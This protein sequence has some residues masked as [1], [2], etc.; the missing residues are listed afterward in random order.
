MQHK[1]LHHILNWTLQYTC[2]LYFLTWN[3]NIWDK[4]RFMNRSCL[5]VLLLPP[6]FWHQC[7]VTCVLQPELGS[8]WRPWRKVP[9]EALSALAQYIYYHSRGTEFSVQQWNCISMMFVPANKFA[10]ELSLSWEYACRV[11]SSIQRSGIALSP[12][13]TSFSLLVC[14]EKIGWPG[15]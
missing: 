14:F 8:W 15:E 5:Q 13:S 2:I 12:G 9:P 7:V 4:A 3:L 10:S 6:V 1:P 11:A